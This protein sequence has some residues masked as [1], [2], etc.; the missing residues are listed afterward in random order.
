MSGGGPDRASP[1][2]EPQVRGQSR[3]PKAPEAN[4]SEF[5]FEFEFEFGLRFRFRFKVRE[6]A[7]LAT[8]V[9]CRIGHL[10][11][12]CVLPEAW[13][14]LLLAACCQQEQNNDRTRNHAALWPSLA[15]AGFDLIVIGQRS[16]GSIGSIGSIAER[17]HEAKRRLEP[18]S[19]G[20]RTR[21]NEGSPAATLR[22]KREPSIT[23]SSP[24]LTP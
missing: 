2:F 19:V 16:I 8:A 9:L 21:I 5:E 23:S 13:V 14:I 10:D 6:A 11:L 15:R 17:A 12:D 4:P 24:S 1:A 18:S 20:R 7:G 22:R 3:A